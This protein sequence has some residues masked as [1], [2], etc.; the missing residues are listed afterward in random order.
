ML[1]ISPPKLPM[2]ITWEKSS[3]Q[4]SMLPERG[5]STLKMHSRKLL[6]CHQR[7]CQAGASTCASLITAKTISSTQLTSAKGKKTH[8]DHVQ[9]RIIYVNGHSQPSHTR[10]NCR[11]SPITLKINSQAKSV[12]KESTPMCQRGTAVWVPFAAQA[13]LHSTF[14]ALELGERLQGGSVTQFCVSNCTSQDSQSLLF[15]HF[16]SLQE[17]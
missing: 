1:L 11:L 17:T 2:K 9:W 6:D 16:K 15:T 5:K 13:A 4:E 10:N 7:A 12:Q 3:P 14:P 8:T